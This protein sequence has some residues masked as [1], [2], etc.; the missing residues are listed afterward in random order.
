MDEPETVSEKEPEKP[1]VTRINNPKPVLTTPYGQTR[2][3]F[4]VDYYRVSEILGLPLWMDRGVIP[5][6]VHVNRTVRTETPVENDQG[7]VEL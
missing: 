6:R 5:G 2:P 3:S 4:A 1:G 7:P